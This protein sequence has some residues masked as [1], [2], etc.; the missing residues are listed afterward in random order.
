MKSLYIIGNGFDIHHGIK[1]R[2]SDYREWLKEY[3][4]DL[5]DKLCRLYDSI[6]EDDGWWKSFEQHL[7]AISFDYINKMYQ[8]YSPIYG[9]EDFRDADYHRAS[10]QVGL[11]IDI[12]NLIENI[13]E[14]HID[15]YPSSEP[16][17][18][19]II[20]VTKTNGDIVDFCLVNIYGEIS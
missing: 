14:R 10:I 4:F 19:Y 2:Y 20:S 18:E 15:K 7:S 3:D 11:D 5:Y 13:R 17:I 8:D 16:M 6:D 12:D 1:S 9:S